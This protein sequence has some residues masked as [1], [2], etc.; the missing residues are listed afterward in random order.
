MAANE[1]KMLSIFKKD[2]SSSESNKKIWADQ[3]LTWMKEYD[4]DPYGNEQK[5]KA[6]VVSRDIK[7]TGV[8][9]HASIIDPFV[10]NENII[11]T[12]PVTASDKQTSEEAGLLL[13]Y[14]FCRDFD[15]FN[16]ISDSFKVLQREGTVIARVSW[17]FEEEEQLVEKPVY[18][19]VPV[20]DPQR[21][22]QMRQQGLPP[23]E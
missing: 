14:Q 13:N 5:G 8:W 7:K 12:I 6:S 2:L 19:L 10:N 21:A 18:G 22:M 23:Y 3:I 4:G 11:N 17:E 1:T 16:F 15:R 20:Q 9:Q